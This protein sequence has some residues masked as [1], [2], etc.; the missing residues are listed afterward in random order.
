MQI[1]SVDPAQ[2]RVQVKVRLLP[3][4]D[5]ASVVGN[6]HRLSVHYLPSYIVSQ[7]L[8]M[9]PLVL[10]RIAGNIQVEKGSRAKYVVIESSFLQF[11]FF[12]I[13]LLLL[14]LSFFYLFI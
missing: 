13:L 12:F 10:A 9:K 5:I 11:F 1:I 14:L 4:P 6:S 3:E 7:Q 8:G 2:V